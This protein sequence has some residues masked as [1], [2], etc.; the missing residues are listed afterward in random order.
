[1]QEINFWSSKNFPT[2]QDFRDHWRE[3]Y[4]RAGWE[5]KDDSENFWRNKFEEIRAAERGTNGN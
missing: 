1:M 3:F 2:W 4:S 5:I